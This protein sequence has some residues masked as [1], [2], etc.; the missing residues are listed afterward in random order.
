MPTYQVTETDGSVYEVDGPEGATEEQIIRAVQDSLTGGGIQEAEE[1]RRA[2]DAYLRR[3]IAARP[4]EIEEPD[5]ID[6]VEELF[7]G[8]PAGAANILES[9]ALGAITPFEE[10]TELALRKGIKGFFDPVQEFFSPDK[11]SENLVG[12]KFGEG[13]GS[14][15]GIGATAAIPGFGLPAAVA[16][17]A[18]AGAGEASERAREGGATEEQRGRASF[19]GAGVGLTELLSPL[20]ILKV[21]KGGIGSDAAEGFI[22]SAKRVALEGGLEGLQEFAAGVGQNLI[23]QK[24]YNPEQG[25][26]EGGA[27]QFGLGA[28]VGGFVRAVVEL[29]TPRRRTG[30]QDELTQGE[31]FEPDTDLGAVPSA[32]GQGELFP[33]E[34]LGA[35]PERADARQLDL[36]GPASSPEGEQQELTFESVPG[37]DAE[38]V[39][40]AG[41]RERAALAA[42]ERN[43]ETAFAQPDL[44]AL[45]QEQEGRRLGTPQFPAD[46]FMDV[47]EETEVAP[48]S[49]IGQQFELEDAIA[50]RQQ[51]DIET[52]QLEEMLGQEA[53]VRDESALETIRGQL[54]AQQ[55]QETA[56]QRS[57]VLDSVLTDIGTASRANIAQR[58]SQALADAGV[59]N[60]TPTQQ[61]Y[62]LISRATD[63]VAATR[64]QRDDVP[65]AGLVPSRKEARAQK[66]TE[67][68]AKDQAAAEQ[69]T[70]TRILTE[71]DLEWGPKQIKDL[72]GQD[73]GNPGPARDRMQQQ[74]EMLEK[75]AK[76]LKKP[77]AIA[78]NKAKQQRARELLS[79]ER[80]TASGTSSVDTTQGE[81][82][83]D[84]TTVGETIPTDAAFA[85]QEGETDGT[86][87]PDID[88]AG[89]NPSDL[90][91]LPVRTGDATPVSV[92]SAVDGD[93]PGPVT[94]ANVGVGDTTPSD[95]GATTGTGEQLDTLTGSLKNVTKTLTE[96]ETAKEVTAK[97]TKKPAPKKPR[98]I[99]GASTSTPVVE[100]AKAKRIAP[101]ALEKEEYPNRG[102]ARSEEE[103]AAM[104]KR[105]PYG[106]MGS[107]VKERLRKGNY[108]VEEDIVTAPSP[109]TSQDNEIIAKLT[110]EGTTTRDNNGISA[111]A[112]LSKF[113]NP[114]TGLASAIFDD[115]NKTPIFKIAKGLTEQEKTEQKLKYGQTGGIHAGRALA[116]AEANL[117]STTQAWIVKEERRIIDE[118][119]KDLKLEANKE[120]IATKLNDAEAEKLQKLDEDRVRLDK[121]E[122]QRR[123]DIN[124][125]GNKLTRQFNAALAKNLNKFKEKLLQID[126]V[127][128][129]DLPTHPEVNNLLRAG[130][131]KEALRVLAATS[132]SS[133]VSQMARKYEQKLGD[134]KVEVVE[135]LTNKAGVSA[136]GLFDP[137]TNTVKINAT[138][139]INAHTILHE[140]THALTSATLANPSHPLTKQLTKLFDDVKD[141]LGTYYGSQNVDEFAAEASSNL[142]FRQALAGINP[143]G[144]PISALQKYLNIIGNFVRR[145]LGMKTKP[146][147][148][149]LNQADQFIE[150][151]LAPAPDSRD[152]GEL[153]M[154]STADGV[155]RVM[156]GLGKVQKKF[157]K[158]ITSKQRQEFSEKAVSFLQ[159]GRIAEGFKTFLL[160]TLGTKSLADVS[161]RNGFGDIGLK[162]HQLIGDQRGDIQKSD[163][164]V[165]KFIKGTYIPWAD[166]NP[167]A[168]AA[169][170]R[171]IYSDEHGATIYQVDP[172]RLQDYYKGKTDDSG[173]D[174]EAI[175]KAQRKDWNI[176]IEKGGVPVFNSMR[177]LYK[178]QYE[179]LEKVINGEID[180]LMQND[181]DA[182][183]RLKNEVFAKLFEAGKLDVYFPLVRQG[184]YKLSY[185][186]KN[187]K[188]PREAYVVRMFD[189]KRERN[190]AKREAEA[191]EGIISIDT[192]DGDMQLKDYSNAPPT[193]FVK[194]TLDILR[195]KSNADTD[196]QEAIMRLF[197]QTL[198]ETSFAKSLQRR[199]GTPGYIQNSLIGLRTKA[200]DIG[201]Q[202]VRLEYAARLRAL[203]GEINGA[204][205]PTTQPAESLMG[206]TKDSISASFESTRAE[207]LSRA[208]FARLGAKNKGMERFYK[209]ANQGAFVYTIGFNVSSAIVNLSQIPLF[210]FPYMGAQHGYKAAYT[211][212]G[213][214]SRFSKLVMI[215]AL[216]K[217]SDGKL[218][219]G[220]K[221]Q[222]DDYYDVDLD[223]NYTVKSG[224]KLY[225]DA[226]KNAETIKELKR[227]APIV[228]LASQRAYLG[229]SFLMD[230]LGLEE[231]GRQA[232]GN[233]ASKL[234][235]NV[236]TVSAFAFNAVERFNRQTIAFANYD[237]I[238]T[239]LDSGDR[240]YS[241]TQG[242]Y[243]P[244]KTL[245]TTQKEELAAEE[246]L[247]QTEQLNGGMSLESAPRIAQEGL[248]RVAFMYKGYGMNMYYAMFKSTARMLDTSIDPALRKQAMREIVGTHGSALLIA[249]VHGVPLYG[250]YTMI[251]NLFLDDEEDDADTIVRKYI[252]E[253][254]YKGP[255][256]A[257]LGVDIASRTRL[258]GLLFQENRYNSDPS[259]EEFLGFYLGGPALSSAKRL[260]RGYDNLREGYFERGIENLLP[261][262]IAN[263]YKASFGRYA[264]EGGIYNKRQDPIYDDITTGELVGQF[265]G[266]APTG[267]TFE[268][269]RNQA[270]MKLG[271]N[272]ND[273]RS[274]LLRKLYL[275]Y[276]MGDAE[277]HADTLKEVRKFNDRY[278]GTKAVISIGTMMRSIK[279]NQQSS[280]KKHNGI[281]L[282]ANLRGLLLQSSSEW[283][284]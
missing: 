140:N 85:I 55:Q 32:A 1:A 184:R 211:A 253:G 254:W 242:K 273:R 202:A 45:Q 195:T 174:L 281:N 246:A 103:I 10:E 247:Y 255:L 94:P 39:A 243:I 191:D 21:L 227:M 83:V 261:P 42:A 192:S 8:I 111:R 147:G 35:A 215:P 256:N 70:N 34:D 271:R 252:K 126:Q 78:A 163:K 151:M 86:G 112:Y 53:A 48:T 272:A 113:D 132:P 12:R 148:S 68:T 91:N 43:D 108:N 74:L 160:G 244:P 144:S 263:A 82:I 65:P 175:W 61:E 102:P 54:D 138:T 199:K 5:I 178:D 77:N 124:R 122:A 224:L 153:L 18:G 248:G 130:K 161:L 176:V 167:K 72:Q 71:Q 90:D 239:K 150:A 69:R 26:F 266:F 101:S 188:S 198:P 128:G 14:F 197:I 89:V 194:N 235:D 11:G 264:R 38:Q 156:E 52:A 276:R 64:T 265:F 134:T 154:S 117:S 44:F 284:G 7:K 73:I 98:K 100:R 185:A 168:Q 229:R 56:Q 80:R 27:E 186:M 180:A 125:K 118:Q 129:L 95:G 28:G 40:Q 249:G 189:T 226:S 201:R 278:S 258:S 172:T 225:D 212:L 114:T 274:K 16:L 62:S 221:D 137:E 236:S 232:Q 267:Y 15:A 19:L 182:A 280:V 268:Q 63:A 219:G 230:E 218:R 93:T 87:N 116:W 216:P 283:G 9:G 41:A 58:F 146:L 260:K 59:A 181:P 22:A 205:E 139:G 29:I 170:D 206:T 196:T 92:S 75:N 123:R 162:V 143:K 88:V 245:N 282:P 250:I 149:A 240:Y 127:V 79:G 158:P 165:N 177:K 60:T 220:E 76:G 47:Q 171:V 4:E 166:A 120:S 33:N 203:E 234:L 109:F 251:A 200:Y 107:P 208:K 277:G 84:T 106:F 36:F 275:S 207:L 131:L 213:K 119:F 217:Y 145:M 262:G 105:T 121:E 193:S 20:R 57:A 222:I 23:E 257:A 228:K 135:N 25:T 173:N 110:D 141:S 209:T 270:L 190:T 30:G 237:L 97:R 136:A 46:Q 169:L 231:G 99:K 13:L 66:G 67:R 142:E 31:L 241:E 279:A 204:K 164:I 214:A 259:P 269:E 152:A 155:K 96:V 115:V 50:A 51:D 223:G 183:K 17:T 179:K 238:L 187:P 6:Q 37:A 24:I 2:Y 157:S 133:R 233:T 104:E 81:D 159:D 3:P 210:A 49:E